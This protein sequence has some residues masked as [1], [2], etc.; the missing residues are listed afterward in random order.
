MKLPSGPDYD[1]VRSLISKSDLHTVCQEAK[2]PNQWECF[3]RRTATFLILGDRCTRNC[4][5]CAVEHGPAEALDPEEPLRVAEAVSNLGLRYV[6]ITSVTRD[7]LSDGGA[8]A[9]ALTIR[10]IRQKISDVL[11]EVLIPDFQGRPGPL[12]ILLDANPDVLNH[13]VETVDRLYPVVRPEAV[14]ERSLQI[15]RRAKN[16][17]E[18]LPLKSGLMLGLGESFEEVHKTLQDLIE[19][20]CTLLTLGQYLQPS[21]NHIPVERF[22]TPAEF[23]QF[24]EIALAMGF[25]KVASGPLVRSS[26][27]AG[28]LFAE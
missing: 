23:E 20:G 26:Y 16:F 22:V 12:E 13:N 9:F 7:D 14:Y 6:V 2:C 5:F 25:S 27:H 28:D 15:F 24:R 10:A 1:L 4:S 17:N 19:A 8:G 18:S 3:A 21:K 11:I